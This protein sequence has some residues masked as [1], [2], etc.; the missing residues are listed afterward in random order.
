MP[1][2]LGWKAT[3]QRVLGRH[4]QDHQELWRSWVG[5]WTALPISYQRHYAGKTTK[6]ILA[7]SRTVLKC[8]T[9]DCVPVR[10]HTKWLYRQGSKCNPKQGSSKSICRSVR[11]GSHLQ[12]TRLLLIDT[13]P[14][15]SSEDILRACFVRLL[16]R[17][18]ALP[19]LT[20]RIPSTCEEISS[21]KRN[22]VNGNSD[23]TKQDSIPYPA[24]PVTIVI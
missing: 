20:D 4:R 24:A 17:P 10:C 12:R 11:Q 6:D 9:L 22:V 3:L 18:R 7:A 21:S 5:L 13:F 8:L 16:P 15:R 14:L 23:N 19:I 1:G 2:S